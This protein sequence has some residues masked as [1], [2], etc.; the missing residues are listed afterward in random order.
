LSEI[1]IKCSVS[2]DL[3][4]CKRPFTLTYDAS[5]FEGMSQEEI[6]KMVADDAYDRAQEL[7]SVDFELPEGLGN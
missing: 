5:D 3:V 6:E 1:K 4:G 7:I 2:M